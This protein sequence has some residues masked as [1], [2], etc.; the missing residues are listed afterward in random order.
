[1]QNELRSTN[2][3]LVGYRGKRALDVAVSLTGLLLLSPFLVILWALV[4]VCLGSP[5]LFRQ[6][7]PGLRG[8][9]FEILKFRSM[10]DERD[11]SGKLLSDEDRLTRL[12]I[13]L[14]K[15]SLDELPELWNVLKGDMSLVGPRPL[16]MEYLSHYTPREKRRHEVRPGITGLA[17]VM[18]RN[19]IGWT[20][21]LECDVRYVESAALSLDLKILARTVVAVLRREN[22]AANTDEVETRLDEERLGNTTNADRQASDVAPA[23]VRS[24]NGRG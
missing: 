8:V 11:E 14:R 5:A 4:R 19:T 6:Q 3:A 23:S 12:G 1:M 2:E 7:R 15:T 9:A 18:G 24:E 21:R 10:T 20:E 13:F 22:V 17:Q 16:L